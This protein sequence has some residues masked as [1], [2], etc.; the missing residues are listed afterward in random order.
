MQLL[1]LHIILG[2]LIRFKLAL[3]CLLIWIPQVHSQ[4]YA[5]FL[6][7]KDL[8]EKAKQAYRLFHYY[9]RHD[10][11]SAKITAFELYLT[12]GASENPYAKA[13]SFRILGAY[14]IRTGRILDGIKK[15]R[16]AAN[17]FTKVQDNTLTSEVFNEIGHGFYLSGEFDEAKKAYTLS[18]KYGESALDKTAAFNGKFG[19]AKTCLL[20]GDTIGGTHLLKEYQEKALAGNKYEAAADATALL[21]EIELAKGNEIRGRNLMKQ[22]FDLSMNAGSEIHKSHAYTNLGIYYFEAG[23]KDSALHCFKR[24]LEI[25]SRLNN[26]KSTCEA[27]FNLGDYFTQLGIREKAIENF[28]RS[29][30]I[31]DSNQLLQDQID[32]LEEL[33]KLFDAQNDRSGRYLEIK[34]Q[35]ESLQKELAYKKGVDDS[36]FEM[37]LKQEDTDTRLKQNRPQQAYAYWML[38]VGIAILGLL[39]F[40]RRDKA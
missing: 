18:L 35:L 14:F 13:M 5:D 9:V 26:P 27:Y 25:R 28:S 24:A 37:V 2:S 39:A 36:I 38:A 29:A 12:D 16:V 21:A 32:A 1:K 30:Q 19:M 22:A 20:M 8:N 34:N 23:K 40:Q 15:L 7:E 11:D 17:Y 6:S 10:L 33:I 31:A 4:Q 3:F